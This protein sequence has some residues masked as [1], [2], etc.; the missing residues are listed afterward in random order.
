MQLYMWIL[1]FD[2]IPRYHFGTI[3]QQFWMGLHLPFHLAILGVVEGSQQLAQARYIYDTTYTLGAK[4]WWGC[5]GS[6][7]EGEALTSSLSKSMEYFKLNE[8]ARGREALGFVYQEIWRLGNT[9]DVCSPANTTDYDNKFHGIPLTFGWFFNHA[10]SAM[11]QAFEIDIPP[12]GIKLTAFTTAL[13][14]WVLV[15]IYFWSAII[16]LLVCYTITSL[17]ADPIA[18]NGN[19]EWWRKYGRWS[20]RTRFFMII[21][22]SVMLGVGCQHHSFIQ[23]FI[24]SGWVLPTVVIQ[25]ALICASDRVTKLFSNKKERKKNQGGAGAQVNE[26]SHHPRLEN[27][28]VFRRRPTNAY[29]YPTNVRN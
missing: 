29:G 4:V 15:Y 18:A 11:I 13:D 2:K 19:K 27:M 9:T 6:N 3:M 23:K 16:L 26:Q 5:V 17:L 28:G 7:L 20:F 10:I 24:S 14:A 1:Y 25:L 8:S 12:E 21:L 22:A